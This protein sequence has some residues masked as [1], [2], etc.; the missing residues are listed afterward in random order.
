MEAIKGPTLQVK[1]SVGGNY[2]GPSTI[3]KQVHTPTD[4]KEASISVHPLF[5]LKTKKIRKKGRGRI[6]AHPLGLKIW[7]Q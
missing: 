3:S 2:T 6:S 1:P 4:E 5:S 7:F